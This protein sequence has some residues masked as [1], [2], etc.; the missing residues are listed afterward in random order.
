MNYRIRLRFALLWILLVVVLGVGGNVYYALRPDAVRARLRQEISRLLAGPFEFSSSELSWLH[1]VVIRDLR[2]RSSAAPGSAS[3]EAER[4]E[5]FE[6]P[7][8]SVRPRLFPLLGGRFE[9]GRVFV[10]SPRLRLHRDRDGRWSF[11][12]LFVPAAGAA[13]D[14]WK[15]IERM[16]AISLANGV[17][18]YTDESTFSKPVSETIE[19]VYLLARGTGRTVDLRGEIE[20]RIGRRLRATL[21]ADFSAAEPVLR[22]QVSAT[23]L[24]LSS[25]I[26]RYLPAG[27]AALVERLEARI[28]FDQVDGRFRYDQSEGFLPIQLNGTILR[29]ELAPAASPFRVQDLRGAFRLMENAVEFSGIEG[30][31]G[32]GRFLLPTV[33]V[34]LTEP[35]LR[36]WKPPRLG[37]WTLL[38]SLEGFTLDRRLR[39]ALPEEYR[40]LLEK[41]GIE[42]KVGLDLR[43]ADA[44]SFPPRPED[45]AAT[46]RLEDV[47][48]AYWE[49]PYPAR[50]LKGEVRIERGRLTVEEPIVGANGL[51]QVAISGWGAELSPDGKIDVTVKVKG[52]PLD[53]KLRRAL[54]AE[55][56]QTW[57]DFELAGQGNGVIE[58]RRTPPQVKPRVTVLIEPVE[59]RT[60]YRRF[61]YEITGISGSV[62]LDTGAK[63]LTFRD[64]HGRHEE[65]IITGSGVVEL[66][67]PGKK[68]QSLYQI[69]LHSDSLEVDDDLVA[70]L[71]EDGRELLE[72]FNFSGRVRA[73]VS[74]HP[75]ESGEAEVKTDL[76]LI[77]G[78]VQYRLFPYALDLAGGRVELVGDETIIVTGVS[79]VE[80][81]RPRVLSS[82]SLTTRG[83]ERKLD[84]SF[85]LSDLNF[86][87]KLSNA[88]PATLAKFVGGMRLG[89]TYRG[90]IEG[91]YT[92][93]EA[94]PEQSSI[95]Y[96]GD[97]ISAD[98]ASVDF[99]LYIHDMKAKGSF[100]GGKP[101]GRSHYLVGEVNVASAWFNRLHLT[102]GEVDFVL[103]EEHE[104]IRMAR[105]GKKIEG[106]DYL[107]GQELRDRL[108]PDKAVDAF[109]MVI[110]SPDLYGGTV[111][112]F[113]YVDLG[114]KNDFGGS[115]VGKDLQVATAAE[116]VFGAKGTGTSGAASGEIEFTGR[117]SDLGSIAGRGEGRIAEARLVELPL[118]FGLLSTIFGEDSSRH[119]FTGVNL[120]YRI[121]EGKFAA[122]SGNGIEILSPGLKLFG[123]G[124]MDFAG[125]LDLMLEPRLLNFQIPILEQIFSLIKKGVARV[126]VTGELTKPQIKFQTAGGLLRI[127][128][129][130]AE[131]PEVPLPSDLEA[132]RTAKQARSDE[133]KD[134]PPGAE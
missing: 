35:W 30:K 90:R 49:F 96:R 131:A 51:V 134:L 113:L 8:V 101:P 34:A 63:R 16:P 91:S 121:A 103:G 50:G 67:P 76:S 20:T 28:F 110:H 12:D 78:R 99:G 32:S 87:S 129:D 132:S 15:G 60:S 33:R 126:A 75:N 66:H 74:I 36:G 40:V 14:L 73:D 120:K 130:T 18:E 127:G 6:A 23:K 88:L 79:T 104:A 80:G 83:P 61:P 68:G 123:G 44:P 81:T 24:D 58:I 116:D 133:R 92:F 122:D 82:G 48:A 41:Y 42:G 65:Q 22:L 71:S 25:S 112:G 70:S 39:E 95:I 57:D 117:L 119:Y 27:L 97:D 118:F 77:E 19:G 115:F 31:F 11:Q 72:Q 17:V 93:N 114:P 84:F 45:I 10:D 21:S 13:P 62:I 98:E 56:R 102:A 109:Q 5:I 105:E 94:E 53:E 52:M 38:G 2:V 108:T 100:V 107:P 43:I 1:G 55:V 37:S 29:G 85:D 111:D 7:A 54:P 46:V 64:L 128:I 106:R 4:L 86:D 3:P 9:I 47:D 69:S 124:T 125:N 89:G 59:V 26:A